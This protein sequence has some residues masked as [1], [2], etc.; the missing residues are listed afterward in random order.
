M[1]ALSTSPAPESRYQHYWRLSEN[2]PDDYSGRRATHLS[3]RYDPGR[4][5]KFSAGK[6]KPSLL[7]TPSCLV[8]PQRK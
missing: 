1:I 8:L 4:L 5:R 6:E 3:R 2:Q 7:P